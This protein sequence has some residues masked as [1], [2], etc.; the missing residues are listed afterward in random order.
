MK[1]KS[2]SSKA[3]VF[4]GYLKYAGRRECAKEKME[5]HWP[6]H[7]ERS[8]QRLQDCI[9]L[10]PRGAAKTGKTKDNMEKDGGER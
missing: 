10:G 6:H 1:T 4:D 8:K 9:N 7:E 3:D 2:T 5:I